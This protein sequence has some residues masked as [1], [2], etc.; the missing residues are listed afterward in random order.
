MLSDGGDTS[1]EEM[2]ATRAM[3]VPVFTIGVGNPAIPHDREVLNL[4]AGE[5]LLSGSSVDLS[6]SITSSGFAL[7]PSSCG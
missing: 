4:T 2:G 7:L 3:S 5:P 6:V 1:A